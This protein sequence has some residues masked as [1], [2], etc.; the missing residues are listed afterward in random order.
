LIHP[1]GDV[2]FPP[3]LSPL[4]LGRAAVSIALSRAIKSA[5][6]SPRRISKERYPI[7]IT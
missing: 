6:R 5:A 7:G 4:Y 3:S 1:P 2:A